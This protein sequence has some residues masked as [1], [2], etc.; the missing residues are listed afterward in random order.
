MSITFAEIQKHYVDGDIDTTSKEFRGEAI[1][2]LNNFSKDIKKLDASYKQSLQ[3]DM[4]EGEQLNFEFDSVPQCASFT[5]KSS[6]EYDIPMED[7]INIA[8]KVAS[9][10]LSTTIDKAALEKTFKAGMLHPDLAAHMHY[11]TQ[12]TFKV[13]KATK[14]QLAAIATS[15][16]DEEEEEE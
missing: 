16:D 5:E 14:A 4:E 10:F 15:I 3:E 13:G 2:K 6:I 11:V 1:V 7:M 12:T 8:R 9:G